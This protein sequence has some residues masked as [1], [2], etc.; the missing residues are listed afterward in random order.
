MIALG[1]ISTLTGVVKW[2]SL[3]E[4]IH[5]RFSTKNLELNLKALQTGIILIDKA[6]VGE[7]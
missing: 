3:T 4:V 5:R 2:E 6:G 1:A 7:V